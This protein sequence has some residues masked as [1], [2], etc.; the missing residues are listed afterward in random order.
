MGNQRRVS[1]AFW[2]SAMTLAM[3]MPG[4][5]C[6]GFQAANLDAYQ[7]LGDGTSG[8][9]QVPSGVQLKYQC[10]AP[11]SRGLS[12]KSMGRTTTAELINS[13]TDLLGADV[14]SDSEIL[15]QLKTL[16]ADVMTFSVD[17]IVPNPPDSQAFT[18]LNIASRA[19]DIIGANPAIQ[20]RIFGDCGTNAGALDQCAQVFIQNFGMRSYQRPLTTAEA[21]SFFAQ[22]KL[23]GGLE[24][25]N[26][27]MIR[28][29]LSPTLV[30]HIEQGDTTQDTRA[31]LTDFE[32]ASRLS[33]RIAGSLPDA[34]L[35]QAAQLGQLKDLSQLR[36]QA[37]RLI[38][39]S[40]SAKAKIADF[41][42]FY[43]KTD[44]I[45]APYLP[46]GQLSGIDAT[47]FQAEM[48]QESIDFTHHIVWDKNG[49]F[50]DLLTSTDVFPRTARMAKILET[51]VSSGNSPSQTTPAH[52]GLLLRPAAF[53]TTSDL[54]KPYH[55]AVVIRK[56][57]LCEQLG[58]PDPN[59]LAT[60]NSLLGDLSDLGNRDRL[61]MLT[62]LPACLGC[63]GALNPVGFALEGYDQLGARRTQESVFDPSGQIVK[64][65]PIDTHVSPTQLYDETGLELKSLD[66]AVDLVRGVVTGSAARACFARRVFEYQ[67]ARG[68][69]AEDNC[70]LRE[71]ESAATDNG[72]ILE[73]FIYGVVNEDIFWKA[74]GI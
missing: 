8:G 71:V 39:N 47:D 5:G 14:M 7:S 28:L 56:G 74:I 34:A 73:A 44:Q 51:S 29:L 4:F 16:P 62:N 6:T 21:A 31:R 52:G 32:V 45:S 40:R 69:L 64:T 38:A 11:L 59:A 53:S 37:K 35:L 72:T 61:T 12:E 48:A 24:G 55:R 2:I 10:T 63:H 65:H 23:A 15:I 43:T 27:V 49:K 26:Q 1:I 33:F 3:F 36:A 25:L 18:M 54:T 60:R 70:A 57:Y 46:A 19:G 13:L 68:A 17:D 22:Y 9:I 20:K 42:R 66:T 30:F 58:S 41:F 67:R 50:N